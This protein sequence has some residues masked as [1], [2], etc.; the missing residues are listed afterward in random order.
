MPCSDGGWSDR[1][2]IVFDEH[3]NP[4]AEMLCTLLQG[5]T[6]GEIKKLPANIR[7]WWKAHQLRDRIKELQE[8]HQKKQ[9]EYQSL[10]KSQMGMGPSGR[11]IVYSAAS[12]VQ[13]KRA[14]TLQEEILSIQL[15]M[16]EL[17]EQMQKV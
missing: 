5:K 12:T 8:L 6:E 7:K 15:Q 3:N 10:A 9:T 1:E 17:N 11:L 13:V 2:Q 14:I 16:A 4:Q